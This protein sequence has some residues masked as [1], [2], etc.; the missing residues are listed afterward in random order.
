MWV[1]GEGRPSRPAKGFRSMRREKW[2]QRIEEIMIDAVVHK[3]SQNHKLMELLLNTGDLQ[4][5]G[6]GENM[7]YGTGMMIADEH[8]LDG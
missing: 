1:R 3:F 4:L 6:V 5:G 8:A 7:R 2:E